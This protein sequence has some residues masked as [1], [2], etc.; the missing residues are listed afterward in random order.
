MNITYILISILWGTCITANLIVIMTFF[1]IK[2]LRD[3]YSYWYTT[4]L[5]TLD[6]IFGSTA[7]PLQIMT[8]N[9]IISVNHFI[10]DLLILY[11]SILGNMEIYVLIGVAIDRYTCVSNPRLNADQRRATIRYFIFITMISI[12]S[13]LIWMIL[14]HDY[15]LKQSN[16]FFGKSIPS[17]VW[18][19]YILISLNLLQ[20]TIMGYFNLKVHLVLRKFNT[21]LQD[22]TKHYIEQREI[23]NHH[24]ELVQLNYEEGKASV[25]QIMTSNPAPTL[26]D[27]AEERRL[28]DGFK[29]LGSKGN[30]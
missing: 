29:N 22:T 14:E 8:I 30:Y 25:I 23:N 11:Q 4:A 24:R 12:T 2:S 5:A 21:I 20:F 19:K 6:L 18:E 27:G 3:N 7:I 15:D 13:I 1:R 9:R 26:H 16:C 28:R 10:C 17:F